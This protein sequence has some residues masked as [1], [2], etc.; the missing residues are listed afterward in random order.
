MRIALTRLAFAAA[1]RMVDGVHRDAAHRRP[2]ATPA[3]RAGLADLA[4][5]VLLVAELADRR[6]TIHMHLAHLA[7]AQPRR[8]VLALA[9]DDL[10]RRA[11]AARELRAL[12]GL[13]RG[14]DARHD[15]IPGLH[16]PGREDV[17]ALAIGIQHEREVRRAVRIVLEAL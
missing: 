5:V 17:A 9:R 15:R 10:H 7:R 1:V 6:A 16:I 12:A 14:I 11:R 4:Q 8:D 13:D 3:L 2:N